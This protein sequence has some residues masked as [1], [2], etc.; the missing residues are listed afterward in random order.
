MSKVW[1]ASDH[2]FWHSNVIEYC[3]R[4][5]NDVFQMNKRLIKNHNAVVKKEDKVFFLGDVCLANKDK[6]K[7]IIDQL[8]GQLVLIMGNHDKGRKVKWWHEVG[9]NEV[10]K[11]PIIYNNSFILSHEPVLNL[12]YNVTNIHGHMH[13]KELFDKTRY[14]NV[15]VEMINYT[16]ILFKDLIGL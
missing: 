5:F 3:N 12:P 10:S 14:Y 13:D 9:F 15:S 7:E 2:H 16:P 6:T 4:P 11:Y 1:F 8:N